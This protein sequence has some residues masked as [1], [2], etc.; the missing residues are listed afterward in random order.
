M[1]FEKEK[2]FYCSL[3]GIKSAELTFDIDYGDGT[4]TNILKDH[5]GK[6]MVF[7]SMAGVLNYMALDEWQLVEILHT[8]ES[9]G[10]EIECILG[11]TI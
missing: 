8:Q 4:G 11:R 9:Q 7:E 1:E 6:K 5:N 10:L 2:T 3:K